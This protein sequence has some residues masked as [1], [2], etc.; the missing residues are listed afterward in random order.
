MSEPVRE[1]ATEMHHPT[2][3]TVEEFVL[4][5]IED[6]DAFMENMGVLDSIPVERYAEDWMKDFVRW[7]EMV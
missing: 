4:A 7:T 2:E 1:A 6:V 3:L 5:I